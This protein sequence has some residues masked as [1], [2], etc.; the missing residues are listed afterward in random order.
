[1]VSAR[2]DVNKQMYFES[3]WIG[4]AAAVAQNL[5]ASEDEPSRAFA[6]WAD[7]PMSGQL[8]FGTLYEQSEAYHIWELGNER[9]P[10]N[11]RVGRRKLRH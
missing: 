5:V 6:Q 3:S 7:L 2:D 4:R 11:T 1:M 9:M 8:I 10:A